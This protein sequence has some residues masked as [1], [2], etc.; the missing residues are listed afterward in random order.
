[1]RIPTLAVCLIATL[2]LYAQWSGDPAAPYA[3]CN[4]PLAQNFV[5][6]RP[7]GAGGT[8]VFWTDQRNGR[9]EI[10]AQ[11]V[12][13]DG[14]ALWEP[15]GRQLL[16]LP[17]GRHVSNYYAAS[18]ATG[19]IFIAYVQ[20]PGLAAGDTVRLARFD[21]DG[22]SLIE[23]H[24]L[25]GGRT[26]QP[27]NSGYACNTTAVLVR[28]D[29]SAFV[30]WVGG[31]RR[32]NV[33]AADGSVPQSFDGVLALPT[34]G[35]APHKLVSDGSGGVILAT[36]YM[37]ANTPASLQRFNFQLEAQWPN[38]LVLPPQP[39]HNV[40]S[41]GL[42]SLGADGFFV[43]WMAAAGEPGDLYVARF[44]VDGTPAWTGVQKHIC[45]GAQALHDH[46]MTL[47]DDH[48]F[49][50]WKKQAVTSRLYA[51]KLT[52]NGDLLW[53]T[54]GALVEPIT[55]G[56]GTLRIVGL[57]DGGAMVTTVGNTYV[58][59]RLS[60]SGEVL[61]GQAAHVA[62]GSFVPEGIWYDLLPTDD[63]GAV[64]FWHNW[65]NNVFGARV[66]PSG[67]LAGPVGVEEHGRSKPLT[68]WPVPAEG[69][70]YLRLPVARM[71]TSVTI[72]GSDG[73]MVPVPFAHAQDDLLHLD[74]QA[75]APGVYLAQVI[76][77]AQRFHARFVKE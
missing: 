25:V 10:W 64:S 33:V 9:R 68:A 67:A 45:S 7:D 74:L 48:L 70:L 41:F 11:R 37:N 50:V 14:I 66:L 23:P 1:M 49:V 27:V 21:M 51:Q 30:S 28:P 36:M 61:W 8:Y 75:L 29:G 58:A 71:P 16:A 73:R 54:E 22:A 40:H 72:H 34:N 26:N 56:V 24:P 18:N 3:I 6:A 43:S 13:A 65:G 62:Q 5:Q 20:S 77:H 76:V 19:G 38:T 69:V 4:A 15:N 63:N 57:A 12:N 32:L 46:Q 52:L 31:G 55:T 2:A 60:S 53:P 44:G 17:G 59:H 47:R 39:G 42:E 35:L